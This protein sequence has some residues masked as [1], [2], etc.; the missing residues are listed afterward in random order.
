MELIT[1]YMPQI[2]TIIG[3][4]AS[5]VIAITS[6]VK[7]L[8]SE[9]R[10]TTDVA[11]TKLAVNEKIKTFG[12]DIK[13]TRAGIV[14]GFKDAVITK[15]LKVSINNQVKKIIDERMDK[16]TELITKNE[17]KRTKLTYWSL[18]ILKNTAAFDKLTVEQQSELDEVMALIAEDEKIVETI[19]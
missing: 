14:Q 2:L 4:I 3:T 15:D 11:Q 6:L 5:A 8:Q 12:E 18:H 9:K 13:I 16:I 19:I 7:A 17:E 1:E 10:V